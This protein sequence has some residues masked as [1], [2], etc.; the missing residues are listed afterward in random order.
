M[1]AATL[2]AA[3]LFLLV[4]ASAA[5]AA[6]ALP[7][8]TAHLTPA[9][10]ISFDLP[11]GWVACDDATNKLLGEAADPHALKGKVCVNIPGV[12]YKLRAFNPKIFQTLTFLFDWQEK[13][14][15]TADELAAITPQ[16]A[17]AITPGVCAEIVKPMTGDGTT[18]ESCNVAVGTF[19]GHIAMVSTIIGIPPGTPVGKFRVEIYEMPYD[20]GYFQVQFNSSVLLLPTTQ[21]VIDAI[22]ASFKVE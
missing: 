20:K 17:T 10:G 2:T 22:K 21:P 3:T 14:D 7:P 18:I 6:P 19:A 8:A 13:Q 16:V 4:A 12:S 5:A 15:I 11:M 1:R 9:P